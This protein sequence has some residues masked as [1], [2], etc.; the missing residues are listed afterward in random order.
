MIFEF[1]GVEILSKYPF[2]TLNQF[3]KQYP[4]F[5]A[6]FLDDLNL[7]ERI[8]NEE[9]YSIYQK[10]HKYD[11][12]LMRNETQTLFPEDLDYL[13]LKGLSGECREKLQ[14]FKPRNMAAASRFFKN[15][16]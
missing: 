10:D 6:E 8:R 4:N 16:N 5:F 7:E 1:N 9:R 11:V 13:S 12:E 15:N 3:S 2:I 14:K